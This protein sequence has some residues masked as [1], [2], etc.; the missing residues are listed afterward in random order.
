MNSLNVVLVSSKYPRNIGLVSRIMSNY[1]IERLILIS[2]QCQLNDD[3]KQGAAQG[4]APLSEATIYSSWQEFYQQEP[5]G[6]RIAFSRRQGRRRASLPL[7]VLLQEEVIDLSRPTY[8]IFGA[9]D[10]GLSADD[11]ELVHRLAHFDLPGDLQ[12]MNLSHSVL[13]AVEQF[14]QAFGKTSLKSFTKEDIKDP[15][16]VLR[17][18][19]EALNFDLSS[20][21]R[22]NALTMLKQ[23]IMRAS[24]SNEELH[25]LEMILQQSMRKIK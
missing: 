22:W 25:K 13:V 16:P 14:Y 11:L 9:E 4:Q 1:G 5:D 20:Q 10:H 23:L 15:E 2:P 7:P 6:L 24:P 21:S 3:A 8:L 18:W 17:Q 19:L 12:S